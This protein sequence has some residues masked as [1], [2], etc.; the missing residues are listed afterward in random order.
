MDPQTPDPAGPGALTRQRNLANLC[1]VIISMAGIAML[2]GYSGQLLSVVLEDHGV[3][4][5]LIGLSGAMQMAGV[6]VAIPLLPW[7]IRRFGPARL[8]MAGAALALFSIAALSQWVDVWFWFPL[9]FA[10]GAA[11]STMWTTGETW[12]NHSSDD[13][14]RGRT[15]SIFMS[16]V[17]MGY[18]SGPFLL[19]ELGSEGLL[20]FA[21]VGVI[22]GIIVLPLIVGLKVRIV[23]EG[24]PSVRLHQYL[25]LAP[26]PM[27]SNLMF[28][29]IGS[30]FIALLAV[31]GLRMGMGA[32]DAARML[33]WMGWGG[34]FM[35]L[36]VAYLAARMDRTLLLAVFVGAG[37]LA[38][39]GL[40][41]I[42]EMGPVMLA[43]YLM[44]FGGMRSAHYGIAMIL[45]G[46]RFR[47]A[48]L[49]SATAVFGLMFGT[50]SIM[51]PALSGVAIDGWDP[52]GLFVAILLFHLVLLPL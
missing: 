11:Q 1:A 17:A 28:G 14:G 34:V 29:A 21:A 3:N 15:V 19:G 5:S 45:V 16:V 22:V 13:R 2:H 31:Y 44:L 30:S 27:F 38:T 8:M 52:H 4:G 12:V 37:A 50:G 51:G 23:S 43:A 41:W 24:R 42:T 6:F 40:P 47:G 9:R 48:D 25:R 18:A 36:L 49:P 35:P 39:L 46:D 20:P 32:A 10:F 7:L 26:V 33:G